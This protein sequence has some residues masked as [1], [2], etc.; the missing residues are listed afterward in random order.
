[1][2]GKNLIIFC[3]GAMGGEGGAPSRNSAK[4]INIFLTLPLPYII[5]IKVERVRTVS[6]VNN[7]ADNEK[8]STYQL[9]K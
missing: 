3:E 9:P 6:H 8:G 1:M 2:S 4:I 5:V 7:Q